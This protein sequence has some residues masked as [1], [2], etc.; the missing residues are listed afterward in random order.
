M[1]IECRH[2]EQS[3]TNTYAYSL[4]WDFESRQSRGEQPVTFGRPL[5]VPARDFKK[6]RPVPA[7]ACKFESR[8]TRP[9]PRAATGGPLA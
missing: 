8:A 5:P 4:F 1:Y 6:L 9:G 2:A 7:R 3:K